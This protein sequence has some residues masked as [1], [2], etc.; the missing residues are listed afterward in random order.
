MPPSAPSAGRSSAHHPATGILILLLALTL[1]PVM[2][3]CAKLLSARLSV[4]EITWARYFI[5]WIFLLPLLLLRY[6]WAAFRPANLPMQLARSAMLLVGTVLFFLGLARMPV[7]DTLALFFIS[8]LATTALSAWLLG[9]KVGARRYA[10]VAIGFIG[11]L[12]IFRPGIGVFR[13]PALFPISAGFCYAFYS[14]WT[15]QLAG[16]A[17]PLVTAGFTALVGC[18]AMTATAPLYW[19]TPTPAEIGL[20]LAVGL[21]AAA[22]HY[23]LILAYER[24]PASLLAPF[25]YFE[26]V[27]AVVVGYVLFGDFPDSWTWVGIA[28]LAAS[29]IYI[30]LRERKLMSQGM[31]A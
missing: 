20:M 23:L 19:V 21:I 6:S 2:D 27:M 28:V 10:A 17:P 24:A 25:G 26:I 14:I 7:A 29:G 22:G 30:S 18:I 13:W 16:T 31:T 5:H 3:G 15:R 4:F 12:I 9:E 11:A 1:L 8:P